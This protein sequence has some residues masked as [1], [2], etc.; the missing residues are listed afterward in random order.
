[1][2]ITLGFTASL[3]DEI[4]LDQYFDSIQ[5]GGQGSYGVPSE[6]FQNVTSTYVLVQTA[7]DIVFENA[8]GELQFVSGAGE[9][10]FPLAATR[11]VSLGTVRGVVK[12]TTAVCSTWFAD[13]KY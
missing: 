5:T 8:L 7:G 11:I 13:Y 1:V 9:G 10:L 3:S 2:A 12:S 4:V 6:A